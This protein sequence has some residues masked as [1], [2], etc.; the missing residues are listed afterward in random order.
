MRNE[1]SRNNLSNAQT[2]L[3]N[4]IGRG[5]VTSSRGARQKNK[6][7]SDEA[8][9][10]FLE[11]RG[12][13]IENALGTTGA[14]LYESG[15]DLISPI[16]GRL[17]G[18]YESKKSKDQREKLDNTLASN[19]QRLDDVVKKYG[20]NSRND[21][22]DASDQAEKNI[23]GKY[24]FDSDEY[25]N[26]HAD[27][28]T[29]A[30][31]D[32]DEV[33]QLEKQRSDVIGRMSKEDADVINKFDAIQNELKGA[34][35]TNKN[36]LDKVVADYNDYVKNNYASQ[37][38]NQDRGKFAG[39]AINTLSTA[40]DVMAPGAGIAAN[41]VQGGLEGVADEL[42]QSGFENFDAERAAQNA[43]VGGVTGGVVG[44]LNKGL[45]TGLAKRG[46][47]LFKGGNAL[48]RGLNN[49]G[50]KTA[51]G[52][53]GSTIATGAARGALS[54]AVGGATGGG[55]SA[56]LNGED[57]LQ[58]ALTGATQG[59]KQGAVMGGA[60]SG[61]NLALSKT[62]VMRSINEAGENWKNSGETFNERL[63]N[64]LNSGDSAVGNW[65]NRKTQSAALGAAGNL[66]N[67]VATINTEVNKPLD[68]WD[69][70]AQQNGYET[71]DDV[72]QSYLKA[73]PDAKLNPNGAA[74]QITSWMDENPG[75]W[76]S[77]TPTTAKGWLKRAGERVVEDLNNS[78]LG[79]RVKD[80]SGEASE[81]IRSTDPDTQWA[82]L[83]DLMAKAV[84]LDT[85][86]LYGAG[87][88]WDRTQQNKILQSE[89]TNDVLSTLTD[90]LKENGTFSDYQSGKINDTQYRE[91]V[92]NTLNSAIG[93]VLNETELQRLSSA[94][95]PTTAKGWA[96]KAASRLIDDINEKGIGLSTKR[97]DNELPQDVRNLE[98]N[99]ND[100]FGYTD[101]NTE[102]ITV[103]QALAGTS[104]KS[105]K[106][107]I[108]TNV[109]EAEVINLDKSFDNPGL[110]EIKNR[111]KAQALG[112]QLQNAAQ[113]QKF[114]GI[115][116]A[117]DAK[118][119]QRAAETSA[120]QRLAELGVNSQDYNEY[121]KTSSYVN[122]VISDLAD[123]SGVKVN[124]LDLPEQLSAE[125][126]SLPF[127]S[128][129][130]L[131]TYNRAIRNLVADGSSPT[132][133]S[134]SQ[135]LEASRRFGKN[136]A[137]I[138]GN[139]EAAR[140]LR[141]AYTEAK[142]K[143]RDIATDALE[144]S[145]VTGEATSAR[146]A[147]GL[148]DLGAN[149]AVQDYYT[150][151]VDGKAPNAA[152]YIRRSSLFEQARDMG[153]QIDAEKYTRSAS[154]TPT[155]G[156][157]RLWRATGLDRPIETLLSNTVAPAASKVTNLT[158]KAIEKAG[159][160]AA[161]SG[162]GASD[163]GNVKVD[164]GVTQPT[165]PAQ[166]DPRTQIYNAIGRTQGELEDTRVERAQ[167]ARDLSDAID[168][169]E[170][171]KD[172][173]LENLVNQLQPYAKNNMA[174]YNTL[175]GTPAQQQQPVSDATLTG[176]N[177]GAQTGTTASNPYFPETGDFWTDVIGDALAKAIDDNDV[178][179]F[180]ELYEMYQ[181]SATNA[182][183][184]AGKDYSN[185]LNWNSSD[186]TKLLDAQS[187]LDQIDQLEQAYA[188]AVE[189]TGGTSNAFQGGLRSKAA[190]INSN[191]DP[192]AANYNNLAQSAGM[193]IVKNL[194]NLGVTEADAQRYL[195]YLPSLAD[196]K[197]QAAQKL[198]TLRN[199]YQSKINNLYSLY[200]TP[201]DSY[202][203]SSNSNLGLLY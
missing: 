35:A 62:P 142:Y 110:S 96:K 119:A 34:S 134:A 128:E 72:I 188:D 192:T 54:G 83:D 52:R 51:I 11:K 64:T 2:R 195:Q 202:G 113:T 198:Q 159:D 10:G 6:G 200:E 187:G 118:T 108:P 164:T 99:R 63:T 82:E 169:A 77:D 158:G 78:N 16:I 31:A 92:K 69:R 15:G 130:N 120:P 199:I 58:S 22:Y 191:W 107:T 40:F 105:R 39:S 100:M 65:L 57:V 47:N 61:A 13:S 71:Y 93:E 91:A 4:T 116:D 104:N 143:L 43:L 127:N 165:Q 112:K 21:F 29:P 151:A 85:R 145:G 27:L 41:A 175:F 74:G 36:A 103:E 68:A 14:A 81:Y 147:Q 7:N 194:V 33:K 179:L 157:T 156:L 203:Y 146:I 177:T 171:N 193:G 129:S 48:T 56:A 26:K 101:D 86:K 79:N 163:G 90:K 87:S 131:K 184:S 123:K 42:E 197:E 140:E 149:Q 135:L 80:V 17:T 1:G 38:I 12:K 190:E 75:N 137:T 20:F 67:R 189:G 161:G 168:R 122:R 44:G 19:N 50:S 55:L 150:E 139:T 180:G 170:N 196:T 148:K 133:Y 23:F 94:Q 37:K 141:N 167:A 162:A 24:G 89:T 109:Q 60:M 97:V 18:K 98:I 84:D 111:N 45:S 102:P 121:A 144:K 76:S 115:Y 154:K 153:N 8:G 124:A 172:S 132:E 138:R 95:T 25:W 73:N 186:R 70:L 160:I 114:S 136:A 117:L 9:S 176:T 30:T 126:L 46:G 3:Y 183:K 155:R 181:K 166:Y 53:A 125:S 174:T 28:W 66:G 106:T 59:A 152:D 49:L 173:T 182:Q 185:P 88:G 178:E 5:A 32:S 201:T